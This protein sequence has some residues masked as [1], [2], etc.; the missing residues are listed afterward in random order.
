M[1]PNKRMLRCYG[2]RKGNI[3]QAFCVDLNLAVQGNSLQEV[4][5]KLHQQV[6]SYLYDALEGEDK[7]YAEQLL[8]RKAP[9][10]FWIKYYYCK[11]LCGFDGARKDF[12]RIFDE[13]MPLI[14]SRTRA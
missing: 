14:P 10:Y 1:K 5:S 4:Q 8:N 2:E 12:C 3:W 7:E 11:L 9:L 13:T 6:S